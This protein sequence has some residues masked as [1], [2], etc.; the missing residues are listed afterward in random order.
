MDWFLYNIGL[1]HEIRLLLEMKFGNDPFIKFY[2]F[3]WMCL[4]GKNKDIKTNSFHVVLVL[5]FIIQ[6]II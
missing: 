1:R 5:L 6:R 2:M 4:K 3:Q